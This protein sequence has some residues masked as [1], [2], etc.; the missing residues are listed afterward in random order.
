MEPCNRFL[1]E[2]I[3][4]PAALRNRNIVLI[5]GPNY[6]AYAARIL[7]GT[8]LTILEDEKTGEEVIYDRTRRSGSSTPFMPKRDESGSCS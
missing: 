5:G 3:V 7:R 1:P 2:N 8:P 6:S 4:G